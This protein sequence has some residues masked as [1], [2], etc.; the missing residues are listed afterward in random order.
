MAIHHLSTLVNKGFL[1]AELEALEGAGLLVA[2]GHGYFGVT[3]PRHILQTTKA[4][5]IWPKRFR[6]IWYAH[7]GSGNTGRTKRRQ[8]QR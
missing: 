2:G 3:Y 6:A 8:G 4:P 5:S 1:S 7:M